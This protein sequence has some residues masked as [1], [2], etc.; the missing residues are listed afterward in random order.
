ME[1]QGR[2]VRKLL[3]SRKMYCL[4]CAVAQAVSCWLLTAVAWVHAQVSPVGFV[5]D[6]VALGQVFQVLQY[7]LITI[8]PP[9]LHILSYIVCGMDSEWGH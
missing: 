6:K 8:I 5:L 9:V 1:I 2:Y 4:G 7:P 3:Q